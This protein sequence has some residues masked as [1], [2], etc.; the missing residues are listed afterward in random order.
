MHKQ[1]SSHIAFI[2]LGIASIFMSGCLEKPTGPATP[3]DTAKGNG[4]YGSHLPDTSTQLISRFTPDSAVVDWNI[5]IFGRGFGERK[6]DLEVFFGTVPAAIYSVNNTRIVATVP[7]NAAHA[8]ITVRRGAM[9]LVSEKSFRPIRSTRVEL[10]IRNIN[11]VWLDSVWHNSYLD[12]DTAE[13]ALYFNNVFTS[14]EVTHG[15]GGIDTIGNP[16]SDI[17]VVLDTVNRRIVMLQ[18]QWSSSSFVDNPGHSGDESSSGTD[19]WTVRDLPYT[20]TPSGFESMI[21]AAA[22]RKEMIDVYSRSYNT[23]GLLRPSVRTELH[24]TGLG[25]PIAGGFVRVTIKRQ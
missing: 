17:F 22:L 10:E 8:P 14:R 6:Q 16:K 9:T 1:I 11:G 23:Y 25:E 3:I 5:E 15:P 24:L 18:W 12:V 13:R 7:P 2:L 20:I 21:D 4:G 19:R